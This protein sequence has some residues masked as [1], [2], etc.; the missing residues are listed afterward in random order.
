MAK[1]TVALR[2]CLLAVVLMVGAVAQAAAFTFTPMSV[3]ISPS[4]SQSVVTFRVTNDSAQQTAVSIKVM[5]R[6]ID[7]QG[8]E[9]NLAA[10]KDF[11][12]FPARVVL[13]PNSFQSIKIQYR[14]SQAISTELAYRVIAEQLPVDF[15]KSEASGVNILLRYVA[16]LYVT[17]KNTEPRI[18]FLSAIGVSK[19]GGRG[20][21]VTIKNE[22]NKHALLFNPLLRI[23]PNSGSPY[24]DLSGDPV[25]EIEGQNILALST[26]SFF[27]PWE[28]AVLGAA[29][30][31]A[32]SAELE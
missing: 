12:V 30:E 26:R 8:V 18:A 25:K 23:R 9:T 6:Q 19:D 31:G 13:K 27:V 2:N 32:F 14:G 20:L 10:D 24:T 16:A 22:G 5:T 7:E 29:Y 11:L 15:S 3:S 4:G 21:S 1:T 28:S 17:P